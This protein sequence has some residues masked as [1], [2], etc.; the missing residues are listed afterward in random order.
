MNGDSTVRCFIDNGV[1]EWPMDVR[2]YRFRGDLW[3]GLT[4]G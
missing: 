2:N 1:K 3:W 4:A